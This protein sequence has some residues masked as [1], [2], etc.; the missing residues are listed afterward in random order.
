METR[1]EIQKSGV[2]LELRL[3]NSNSIKYNARINEIGATDNRQIG[4]TNTFSLP[5][6]HDNIRALG[7]NV[8]LSNSFKT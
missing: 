7:I 1:I 4:R 2:W 3:L 5:S 6:T 8:F